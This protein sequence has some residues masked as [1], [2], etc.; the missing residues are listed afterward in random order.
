MNGDPTLHPARDRRIDRCYVIGILLVVAGHSGAD[1]QFASTALFRWIYAFHMPLFFALSGYLFRYGGGSRRIAAGAFVR[2]RALRL[3]VPLGVWTTLV[4]LPKGLLSAYAM[5]PSELSWAAYLHAFLYPAD[6][7]IRPYW[8]L[9]VLFEA[10][11]AGYAV[12]RIVRGRRAALVS[13]ATA[14][15]VVNRLLAPTGGE[16][17]MLPDMLWYTGFFLL[18]MAACDLRERFWQWLSHPAAPFVWGAASLATLR[19]PSHA[20]APFYAAAG[21]LFVASCAAAAG[22]RRARLPLAD[23]LRPYTFTIYLLHVLPVGLLRGLLYPRLTIDPALF[24]ALLF[25]SGVAAPWAAGSVLRRRL[26]SVAGGRLGCRL[27]GL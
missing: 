17:L 23:E 21:I 20:A 8:F 27:L 26:P 9:E 2:R 19:Y 16:L 11:L 14:C 22:G 3:L 15:I 25:L 7:P 1:A 24:S 4:F 6:N 10:N 13:A 12:D 5:R 18:G